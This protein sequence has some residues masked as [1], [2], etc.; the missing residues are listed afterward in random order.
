MND[1]S[2]DIGVDAGTGSARAGVFDRA[3]RMV[4]SGRHPIKARLPETQYEVKVTYTGNAFSNMV[5]LRTDE[6]LELHPLMEKLLPVAPHHDGCS[7]KGHAGR[8]A[9]ACLDTRTRSRRYGTRYAGGRSLA[10]EE[11]FSRTV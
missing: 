6:G 1:E 8:R 5:E 11:E 9:D 4:G 7:A 10:H 2:F 3:G